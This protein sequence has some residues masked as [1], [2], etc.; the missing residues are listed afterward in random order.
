MSVGIGGSKSGPLSP[1]VKLRILRNICTMLTT[2]CNIQAS[3]R[4]RMSVPTRVAGLRS[5]ACGLH[6]TYPHS[7]LAFTVVRI[8]DIGSTRTLSRRRA[9]SVH[10]IANN[11]HN[12]EEKCCS[13]LTSASRRHFRMGIRQTALARRSASG[14]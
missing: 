2:C 9:S 3:L 11:Q 8:Q 6:S 1:R 10:K 12:K 4:L 13:Q 14:A 7:H 5:V